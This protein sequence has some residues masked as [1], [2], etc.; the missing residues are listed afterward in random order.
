MAEQLGFITTG[1]RGQPKIKTPSVPG[2]KE[3][4]RFNGPAYDVD[5]DTARLSG[6]IGRIFELMKDGAWRTLD[7]ISSATGDPP[8]SCS[9]ELRHLRKERF[10][11]HTVD[12]RHRGEPADGLWEYRLIVNGGS[13]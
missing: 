8:A 1:A 7:E 6:Q 10:G 9:A 2:A 12:K 4:M 11:K 5:R 3:P 13:R